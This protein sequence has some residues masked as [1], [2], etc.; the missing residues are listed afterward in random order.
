MVHSDSI[1]IDVLEVGT[2]EKN[3]K[4]KTLT[5]LFGRNLKRGL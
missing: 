1:S 4:A 5:G 3:L 2:A